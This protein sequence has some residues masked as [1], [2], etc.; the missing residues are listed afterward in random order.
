MVRLRIGALADDTLVNLSVVLPTG[1]AR[2]LA[3]HA[4][5]QSTELC[6]P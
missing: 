2:Y 6:K 3:S 5:V 4:H 1:V